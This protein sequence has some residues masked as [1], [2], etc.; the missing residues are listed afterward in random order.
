MLENLK[1][2]AYSEHIQHNNLRYFLLTLLMRL[3][4]GEPGDYALKME[5][6]A[7]RT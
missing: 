7:M 6:N 4:D 3:S 5:S 1:I 2:L